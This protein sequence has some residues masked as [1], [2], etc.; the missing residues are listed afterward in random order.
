MILDR[1]LE[2]DAV[3][4]EMHHPAQR[5][6]EPALVFAFEVRPYQRESAAVGRFIERRQPVARAKHRVVGTIGCGHKQVE[7]LAKVRLGL[8]TPTGVFVHEPGQS[9]GALVKGERETVILDHDGLCPD[10]IETIGIMHRRTL[11]RPSTL[12]ADAVVEAAHEQERHQ[13][14]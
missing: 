14:T 13:A 6:I 11:A 2:S 3:A 1:H 12:R 7:R 5:N 9:A 8:P 4:V 10:R